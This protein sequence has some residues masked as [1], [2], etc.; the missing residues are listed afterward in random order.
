MR[1]EGETAYEPDV[2]VRM[3]AHKANRREAAVPLAHVE[4]DRSGVL[5]GQS[6]PWPTFDNLA[7]PL[8]GLLGA[9]HAVA[10]SDD[11][12]GL[13][14]GEALARHGFGQADAVGAL[15]R[16]GKELTPQ[17]KGVLEAKDLARVRKAYATRLGQLKGED[18]A[19]IGTNG[20]ADAGIPAGGTS[21]P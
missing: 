5:A 2:L 8:L 14:D 4:K 18:A 10:A 21:N 13:L 7:R 12:V 15:E 17:V 1:A 9:T 3:E 11:E 19:A 20:R 16:V 6:L